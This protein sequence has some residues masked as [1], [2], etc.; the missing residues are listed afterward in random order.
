MIDFFSQEVAPERAIFG[1]FEA[2]NAPADAKFDG[3]LA[4]RPQQREFL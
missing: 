1:M 3:L 2:K 4:Q